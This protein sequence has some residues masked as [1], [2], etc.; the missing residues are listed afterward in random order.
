MGLLAAL[1]YYKAGF[2]D[3]TVAGFLAAGFFLGASIGAI[4]AT[5][6]NADVL[7]RIFGAFL[8]A[9]SLHMIFDRHGK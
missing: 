9:M 8:F 6:M 5:R 2:V 3:F 7:R 4:G 1:R